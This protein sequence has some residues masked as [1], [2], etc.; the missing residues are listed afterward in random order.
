MKYQLEL[1]IEQPRDRVIEMFLDP[2]NLQKWQPDLVSLESISDGDPR[3]VGAKCRLVHRMGKREV[4]MIETI[5]VYNPPEEFSATYEAHKVW[6]LIENRFFEAGPDKTRW[7]L[8]CEFRCG[9][10]V[11]IMAIVMPGMFRKQTMKFMQQF[12][13]FA[14]SRG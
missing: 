10:I 13:A 3:A 12:K 14:E 5:T 7:V 8:D 9:G 11:R 4:V 2:D 6:N 1:D